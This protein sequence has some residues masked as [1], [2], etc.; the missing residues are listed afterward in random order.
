L[1]ISSSKYQ[2]GTVIEKK[3]LKKIKVKIYC[4]ETHKTRNKNI[5]TDKIERD[6]CN[7]DDIVLQ[8]RECTVLCYLVIIFITSKYYNILHD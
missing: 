2:R 6:I 3:E 1:K 4:E 7:P 8:R 5:S